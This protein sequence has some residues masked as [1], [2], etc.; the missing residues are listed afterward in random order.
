MVLR[1]FPLRDLLRSPSSQLE[2]LSKRVGYASWD[3]QF[4]ISSTDNRQQ[5]SVIERKNRGE[6]RQDGLGR[7]E[8]GKREEKEAPPAAQSHDFLGKV[9]PRGAVS[10]TIVCTHSHHTNSN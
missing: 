2:D 6:V 3:F 8:Y 5:S 9:L 7:E 4:S 10:C 1:W